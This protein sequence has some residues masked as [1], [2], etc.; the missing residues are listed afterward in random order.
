ME[1]SAPQ[2]SWTYRHGS[3][4]ECGRS[5]ADLSAADRPLLLSAAVA[6]LV[7]GD[8]EPMG[9]FPIKASVSL[10]SSTPRPSESG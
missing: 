1:T 2:G 9:A 8:L 7:G 3:R 5:V 4:R 10:W 6:E